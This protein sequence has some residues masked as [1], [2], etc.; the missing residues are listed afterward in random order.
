MGTFKKETQ[1]DKTTPRFICV[2]ATVVC[3]HVQITANV[4]TEKIL[5]G[6]PPSSALPR[7]FVCAPGIPP[8]S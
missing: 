2:L 4:G 5:D 1:K 6:K 3:G 7:P 8:T